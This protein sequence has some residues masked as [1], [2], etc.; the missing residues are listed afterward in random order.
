[1]FW[2]QCHLEILAIKL[3]FKTKIAILK[4]RLVKTGADG[5]RWNMQK[6]VNMVKLVD[7]VNMVLVASE[8]DVVL[9]LCLCPH[10]SPLRSKFI[11]LSTTLQHLKIFN[12]N[13]YTAQCPVHPPASMPSNIHNLLQ[14]HFPASSRNICARLR[15]FAK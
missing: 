11:A 14:I 2:S 7:M 8:N 9:P 4:S 1:M 12:H 15:C 13:L 5:R 10:V 6:G 3:V